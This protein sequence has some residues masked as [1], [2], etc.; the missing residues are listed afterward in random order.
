MGLD[1]ILMANFGLPEKKKKDGRCTRTRDLGDNIA[2][3][4]Y[5]KR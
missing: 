2:M 3:G 5:Q 1:R 4:N